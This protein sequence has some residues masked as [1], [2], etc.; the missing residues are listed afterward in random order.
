MKGTNRPEGRP[1]QERNSGEEGHDR[2][3]SRANR[4]PHLVRGNEAAKR[5]RQTRFTA[6]MH[7]VDERALER[8][9]RRLRRAAAAGVD[10]ITVKTYAEGLEDR[11]SD[12]CDRVHSGRY[13]PLPVRRVYIPKA[14]G[15]ERPLGICALEDK[16]VQG[17]VAELLSAIYEA[18]F[19]ECS[20]GFRPGLSSHQALRQIHEAIMSEKVNWVLEADI[21][22]FLERPRGRGS[23]PSGKR[24]S[25]LCT[26]SVGKAVATAACDRYH[27][28]GAL[29]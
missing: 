28:S 13:R 17:A 29:R 22:K 3:Q 8:A 20:Y 12:L 4:P 21:R 18:D 26:G 10:G 16:I 5:S 1:Q 7:H 25:A 9:Y 27:A 2:T 11:L 6:L 24:F 15:G 19:L 14:D 23:A